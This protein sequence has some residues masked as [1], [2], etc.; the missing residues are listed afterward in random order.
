M[1]EIRTSVVYRT[2][3]CAINVRFDSDKDVFIIV[4][5]CLRGLS[6]MI[7]NNVNINER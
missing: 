3:L 6:F 5:F 7:F 4:E 2:R 1:Y